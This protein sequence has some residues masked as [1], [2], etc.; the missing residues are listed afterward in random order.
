[1]IKY[2]HHIFITF[3]L[4]TVIVFCTIATTLAQAKLTESSKVAINGIGPILIGMTITQASQAANIQ[5]VQ[6]ASGGESYGCFYFEPKDSPKGIAFM[7]TDDRITRVD[8]FKNNR[9]TTIKGAKIGDS[10]DRIKSLYPGYIQVTPHQ[11]VGG[12][13]YLTFVPKDAADRNYRVVF[14]TDGKRVTSFRSGKL[15]E[16]GYIE[17]CV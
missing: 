1:M 8:I 7:L 11:Y 3:L 2:R 17:G 9:I 14:E 15:P 10:E 12:G 5:F 6:T 16:V 4:S 13:H